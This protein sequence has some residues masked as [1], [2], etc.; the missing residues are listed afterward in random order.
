MGNDEME[1]F[2]RVVLEKKRS[3][4][5]RKLVSAL[6]DFKGKT[7]GLYDGIDLSGL[8]RFVRARGKGQP[9]TFVI[10]GRD[11]E[12]KDCEILIRTSLKLSGVEGRKA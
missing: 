12:E 6:D 1:N 5:A 11:L 10:L 7:Y 9:A 8:I 3:Q 4:D 2:V